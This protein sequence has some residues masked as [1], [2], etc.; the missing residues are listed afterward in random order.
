MRTK[1]SLILTLAAWLLATGTHWDLVQ[2]YAWGRMIV[3]YSQTMSL[4]EAV[5]KTFT[6]ET[7]CGIC[8]SVATAKQSSAGKDAVPGASAPCK[9]FLACA[10]ISERFI[11][12]AAQ[13]QGLFFQ[14][15]I[16]VST[17]RATPPSPPPRGLA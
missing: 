14:A 17:G 2:T 15:F 13:P 10:P 9:I 16:A 4:S 8:Q 5:T 1:L 7:M 6:P 11:S 12:P 3:T